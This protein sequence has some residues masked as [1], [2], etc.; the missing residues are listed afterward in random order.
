MILMIKEYISCLEASQCSE[1]NRS[2]DQSRF[3]VASDY[4]NI[5]RMSATTNIV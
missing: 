2:R 3:K 4:L 1:I 5:L